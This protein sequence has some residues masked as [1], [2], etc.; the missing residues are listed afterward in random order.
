MPSPL[1]RAFHRVAVS[2]SMARSASNSAAPASSPAVRCALPPRRCEPDDGLDR[3][4]ADASIGGQDGRLQRAALREGD[5]PVVDR[6]PRGR[7]CA[8]EGV[9]DRL[10][11]GMGESHPAVAAPLGNRGGRGERLLEQPDLR[12]GGLEAR[13]RDA[14]A[15]LPGRD[16]YAE[17]QQALVSDGR[18]L[19]DRRRR[20]PG[21]AVPGLDDEGLDPLA[22]V[23]DGLLQRDDVEG[24]G[25]GEGQGHGRAGVAG[26]GF[27]PGV[28]VAVVHQRRV[29][30]GIGAVG[31]EACAGREVVREGGFDDLG[32]PSER[33]SWSSGIRPRVSGARFRSM[34]PLRP[35][36]V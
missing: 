5:G 32:H 28:Q 4:E 16:G 22:A 1:A 10:R 2:A 8:V 14:H 36:D 21:R 12:Q 19:V 27:P 18:L 26:S 25:G 34:L 3:D 30:R 24:G 17:T 20:G 13:G 9:H 11:V 6:R 15:H 23:V 29:V 35:I 31:G 33:R 7:R